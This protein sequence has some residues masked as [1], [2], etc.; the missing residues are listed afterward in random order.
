MDEAHASTF[1]T[2]RPGLSAHGPPADADIQR[3]HRPSLAWFDARVTDETKDR[4]F[5]RLT[6][7]LDRQR[8]CDC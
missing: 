3:A 2:G 8:T 7:G 4:S 6:L 5:A 1:S